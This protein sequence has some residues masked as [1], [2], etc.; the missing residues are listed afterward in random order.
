MTWTVN[1]GALDSVPQ[2]STITVTPVNDAPVIEI[3][4]TIPYH[5]SVPSILLPTAP[6]TGQDIPIKLSSASPTGAISIADSDAQ[7]GELSV[8]L[9]SL[10]GLMSLSKTADLSSVFVLPKDG[11]TQSDGVDEVLMSLSGTIDQINAALDGLVFQPNTGFYGTAKVFVTVNDVGNS[12]LGGPYQTQG[13]LDIQITPGGTPDQAPVDNVPATLSTAVDAHLSFTGQAALSISDPDIGDAAI[14]A[15]L[16]SYN[17]IVEAPITQGISVVTGDPANGDHVIVVTGTL[18]DINNFLAGA[19]FIPDPGFQGWASV[20]F[21]SNDLGNTGTGGGLNGLSDL[22]RINIAVGIS[23]S[24]PLPADNPPVNTAPTVVQ[25]AYVNTVLDFSADNNNKIS[26][27]DDGPSDAIMAVKINANNGL[28]SLSTTDNLYF[29]QGDGSY[30][31]IIFVAGKMADINSS[32]DGL[33]FSPMPGYTGPASIGLYNLGQLT[34]SGEG[35]LWAS[36]SIPIKVNSLNPIPIPQAPV[37][38]VPTEVLSTGE[39]APLVFNAEN[40]SLV[41]VSDADIGDGNIGMRVAASNGTVSLSSID[42]L[43]FWQGDGTD[44]TVIRFEGS[45]THVKDALNGLM[46]KPTEGYTGWADVQFV[47]IDLSKPLMYGY[48]VDTDKVDINVVP[49]VAIE[50]LPFVF[51]SANGNQIVVSDVDTGTGQ[52]AV[53]VSATNGTLALGSMDN[54][55]VVSGVNDSPNLTVQ[56]QLADINHALEGLTFN[57]D[58]NYNGPA[59]VNVEVNDQGAYPGPALT[60]TVH[61][62]IMVT[63]VNDAPVNSVPL[64]TQTMTETRDLALPTSLVFDSTHGNAITVS[65]PDTYPVGGMAQVTLDSTHGNL[66][67]GHTD[68]V[69]VSGDQT[70]HITVTGSLEAINHALDGLAYR[71]D[72]KYNGLASVTVTTDDLGNTGIGGHKTDTDTISITV[73]GINDAPVNSLPVIQSTDED[74]TLIFSVAKGNAISITDVDAG[75]SPVKVQLTATKGTL[76]LSGIAGLDFSAGVGDGVDDVTM[77]F[78]GSIENVNAALDGMVFTP[79]LNYNGPASLKIVTND[80]GNTGSGGAKSDTDTLAITVNATPDNPVAKDFALV[81]NEDTVKTVTGWAFT[82]VDGTTAQSIKVVEGP[83]H[84]TLFLDGNGNNLIDNGEA[85]STG[86]VI[87]WTDA[88]TILKYVGDSD[89]NGSDS[90]QYV[91]IDSAGTEGSLANGDAGTV[92]VTVNVVNDAPV[93]GNITASTLEDTGVVLTGWSFSDSKDQVSGGSSANNP[94]YVKISSLPLNGSLFNDGVAVKAGDSI[95]WDNAVSGKLVFQPK[96]DW[97]GTTSF[98][99]TVIDDGGTANGGKNT[100]ASAT[101]T[102]TVNATPDNPVAKDFALVVNEDTVKTVT[103]WAFTTVDGTTAQSIKVV[104]GPGHGTLF[105]DGNGNNLIDNG[106]AVSTG[107]VIGWTDARTILKYVGDSDYNGSDSLQYVVIDS[108]GTEGSLANG[109]AG[110]VS[111]TVNVVNDAPVTGNITAS[112]L[113]DTGVVLTGWS[114]SDSKDQVSGGSSANNPQYVKI[115]SLPL[116]GSLFNDGVAVKAGDSITWD[117]AVSGKLVFQPKADWNGTTSFLFTVIDD[118][119]TANG[120]KNTSASA[121]ATITVNATPD[122]PVAKDFALVVNEDTV[123]TV[124]GWAFTTVDGTTAQSI[125][126]VSLPVHGTLF[127]DANGDNKVDS[128][129]VVAL[130]QVISWADAKT[131]PKVKYIGSQDYNGMDS[132]QY[133]VI[134]SAG[135]EGSLANGD[136]GT[137]S[138][139]VNVVNDAPVTGNITASTLEDTGVVLTGWSFSDS[140]DQVS[141]GSS[142]NNPQYVKISSLPLNGSLFNDGV[143]VK[144]GDSITWDNAVSGKLVFQPK[145]DWNGTTSFLFTVIDDGGTANGGKNTSASATA[146]ITVNATPDN[147]VAK[148]FALVVNEDTVKTVTGW[149]FTTVDGTTAQSIKVVSLPVHGTLFIDANGDNKVDS[150]EVVALNQVISWADAKTVPKVKYIGSQDYNGMD[151]LQYVVID[152]AGTEGSLANG[153]A[154]TVSVT[155]N[156]VN[157]APVTGNI[158][159]STLED[160]GVVLT[161]WSFSDSKDQ[162]SGGSSANNPQYVKISSLPLNGSLFNDGVAVKAGDSITWDNAVSGKLVFQPKADWNGTTSFLFTVIDDGGTANGG[163]NTSAS[164]TATITV[165]ATPDNPVAKDFALVVNEDTVKTVTGW[166]FTTVDGTTAQ[167]IKVVSLPVH[168]TLFIDA[169]GDNKVDSGEVVALNQVI[170]WADAKTVP[171]VKY[172][173]SQDYNGMDSLQYVVIDSAGTEGSLANG[174][175]GTVSVTVNVVNDAPVTGNITASTLED[176]GVVLTGWSFSDSKDQVSGG[177]SANNPQYVKISSLPLNGSLFN[178]GVAVKAGDSITWD[179]AVSGKLVFQ[180][181]ADWNGTTSF[182]FTVIDDGGTAN[183]GKNTSASA[184]ATITVT[185]VNDP[186]VN[187]LGATEVTTAVNTNLVFSSSNANQ[188]TISDVDAGT[189]QVEVSLSTLHGVITL[190]GKSGI[191]FESGDGVADSSM[192]IRGKL[193]DIN[194]ALNGMYVTP[195]TGYDGGAFLSILTNDLGN[196]GLGGAMDSGVSTIKIG[197]G[198]DPN[199]VIW[200]DLL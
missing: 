63:P 135:T 51:S 5:D 176:T 24:D 96:A 191:T 131:V 181:K 132:L 89:Y 77:T 70:A 178:D 21:G 143:A 129:E 28:V 103:G 2:A 183:G 116:N 87:G 81:V 23:T 163:K 189:N 141:G 52:I 197:V 171:K 173:G 80:Q 88:R 155:V 100:S 130:N 150:G 58:D 142:A 186:P 169:N 95:T 165:N 111:V 91:V 120:G 11:K 94:Q 104:E 167:S 82:T 149:A 102:I 194:R 185:A 138:V 76:T 158:T 39:N 139:T 110:T 53:T 50:D 33:T 137:V 34:P 32:L 66:I 20:T 42:G 67:L 30:D 128:G 193:A 190:N 43:T 90:L 166:A 7:G 98:L 179:N 13:V 188:I 83:G 79:T 140:K 199:T 73:T 196:A 156:V 123:K 160:T 84:G 133:V 16:L 109:D 35:F 161:G 99:F 17:G 8:S 107:T 46:F 36:S 40:G 72:L 10:N 92:S 14:R 1:D 78:T 119:G 3:G 172:I 48:S 105:L 97:N 115:S 108:A 71:P 27:S 112:T 159:A 60:D 62:S 180:P 152:S 127:I 55:S 144:A 117:N 170:S 168:G 64:V 200:S 121:T 44:D 26:V 146:T 126:V 25:Q 182:L 22:D 162:V 31:K 187:I 154:G 151:S 175:A 147:P 195:E 125:K 49:G 65:D 69:T 101:A 124:T 74:T 157:D 59:M 86:T 37:N 174:D 12:G 6:T 164:A 85:V 47:T 113:E 38:L 184:T 19:Q 122:N 148:D 118:G 68:G 54:I 15:S 93:T 9:Y 29:I 145:A 57:P 106:E 134:D 153:D 114:F 41:S 61:Y 136:A 198:V 75:D 177:S 45:I 18:V 56:G 192:I 4:D